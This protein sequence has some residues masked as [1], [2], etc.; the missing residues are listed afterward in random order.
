MLNKHDSQAGYEQKA[1]VFC[2]FQSFKNIFLII[3][4]EQFI[5]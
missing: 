1:T 3:Q 4:W 5:Q 2:F